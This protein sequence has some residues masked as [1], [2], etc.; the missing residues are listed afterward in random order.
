MAASYK[1]KVYRSC[2]GDRLEFAD[3]A[4]LGISGTNVLSTAGAL[5][6]LRDT[7]ETATSGVVKTLS[8]Y[9]ALVLNVATTPVGHLDYEVTPAVGRTLDVLCLYSTSTGSLNLL[10]TGTFDGTNKRV[11]FSTGGT[12]PQFIR[13]VGVSTTR[14]YVFGATTGW[15]YS[16]T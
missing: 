1:P 8:G 16:N 5:K 9:G 11:M 2:G 14:W 15:A 6:D 12:N 3:G 7:V 13:L 4:E 10:T